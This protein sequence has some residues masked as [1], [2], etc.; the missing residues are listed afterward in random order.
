MVIPALREHLAA[1]YFPLYQGLRDELMATL[2]DA[3]LAVTLGGTT[4]SLGALCKAIG[5]IE[6]AYVE[7]FRTFSQDFSYRNPDPVERSVAAL[8]AWYTRLDRDLMTVLETLTED[9]VEHRR[10]VRG[11]F[12]PGFFS[13]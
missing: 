8:A 1:T 4:S 12:D 6:H 11:D 13:R 2:S 9:D 7:S 5:E 3:D 10:I